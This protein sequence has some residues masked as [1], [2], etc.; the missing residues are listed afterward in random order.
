MISRTATLRLATAEDAPPIASMARDLIEHGLGWSWTRVRVARNI[1]HP[2]SSTVVACSGTQV[3][4]FAIMYFGDDHAHLN[5]LAVRRAS[6]A[7]GRR[8]YR[9][10]GFQEVA[11]LPRYYGAREAAVWMA[12][13]LR[14]RA[15]SQPGLIPPVG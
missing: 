7:P 15:R 6:N 9:A 10:L 1:G 12:R 3:V 13:D 2:E 4:G 14:T 11:L 8:F 5:L